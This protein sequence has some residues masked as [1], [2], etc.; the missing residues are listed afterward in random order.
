MSINIFSKKYWI[1]WLIGVGVVLLVGSGALWCFKLSVQ[2]ERVFW[3]TIEQSLSTSGVTLSS[4][5][6]QGEAT[7]E[8]NMQFSL[9]ADS[10][11]LSSTTLRQGGAVVV[12]QVLGTMDADYTRYSH[13]QTDRTNAQGQPLDLSKVLNVWAKS[14]HAKGESPLISQT[15]LGLTSALGSMPIPIGKLNPEQRHNLMQQIKNESVYEVA[16]KDAKK[17]VTDGRL[18]YTYEVKIQSIPYVHLVK[19]F[20]KQVGLHD[21]DELD[22][23]DYQGEPLTVHIKIDARARH[24]VSVDVPSADFHQSFTS[25]DIPV[26]V[27]VPK[28]SIPAEELQNRLNELQ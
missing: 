6:T 27:E 26:A 21:L 15:V 1:H 14:D 19:E 9:G 17:E 11:A 3:N 8:Q 16:F 20:A 5:L 12:T 7:L 22:P 2:P 4:N 25:Y 18:Y 13:I 24:I 10:K 23:N 28:D